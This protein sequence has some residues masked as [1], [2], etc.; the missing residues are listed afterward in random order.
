M[1]KI[2]FASREHEAFYEQML[3]RCGNRDCYHQ[4]FFYCLGI[5]AETRENV[6]S[7]F[8][9]DE[10]CIRFEGMEQGWQTSGSRRLC[11]LDYNLWNGYIEEGA[12]RMSTPYGLFDCSYSPYFMEAVRIRYPEYFR[13]DRTLAELREKQGR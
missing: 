3:K 11:R 8:D 5:A 9:L 6:E 4:A 2:R 13:G 1:E 12:E 10:D 7:L